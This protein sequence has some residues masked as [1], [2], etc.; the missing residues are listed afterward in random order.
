MLLLHGIS[1]S[2]TCW[3]VNSPDESL[4]FIL[5]DNGACQS[6]TVAILSLYIMN[7]TPCLSCKLGVTSTSL[8]VCTSWQALAQLFD[9]KDQISPLV[10][11]VC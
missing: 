10:L 9:T 6:L 5:A 7:T 1:L 11:G 4:A 8:S 2:S 3:V